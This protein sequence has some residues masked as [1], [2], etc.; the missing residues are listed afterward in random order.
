[1]IKQGVEPYLE[2]SSRGDKRFSALYARLASYNLNSIEQLYQSSKQFDLDQPGVDTMGHMKN[3]RDAKGKTP[4]NLAFVAWLYDHL[5]RIYLMEHPEF[6]AVL[7]QASGL[8][9]VFGQPGSQCQAVTLWSIR[10]EYKA[11]GGIRLPPRPT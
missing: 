9:D 3:W 5:W 1:M 8:S 10:E 4:K 2:V 7:I 11:T 6:I